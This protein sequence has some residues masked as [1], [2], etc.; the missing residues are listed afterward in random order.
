MTRGAVGCHR[1]LSPP[2]VQ[3]HYTSEGGADGC[4]TQGE[5]VA[6]TTVLAYNC[7]A[8][9]RD[10]LKRRLQEEDARISLCQDPYKE[11]RKVQYEV[12][13]ASQRLARTG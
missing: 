12:T 6:Q 1:L 2:Y 7:R 10:V 8:S 5:C 3:A 9:D 13:Q 4:C 11:L